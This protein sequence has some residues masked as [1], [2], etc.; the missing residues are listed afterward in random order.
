MITNIIEPTKKKKTIHKSESQV[1][2]KLELGS[3]FLI[4]FHFII[5]RKGD[6]QM[7][8]FFQ[9]AAHHHYHR[10]FLYVLHRK[11]KLIVILWSSVDK[12]H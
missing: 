3:S 7:Y 12:I 9:A 2:L 5:S 4:E 8:C 1:S 6:T 10:I 11:P